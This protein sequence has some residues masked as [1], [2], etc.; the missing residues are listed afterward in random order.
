MG[1]PEFNDLEGKIDQCRAADPHASTPH[2][3]QP[4]ERMGTF[5]HGLPKNGVS[6]QEG[7]I[8]RLPQEDHPCPVVV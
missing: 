3:M 2:C 4:Y 6:V 5:G 7:R 8:S 1:E